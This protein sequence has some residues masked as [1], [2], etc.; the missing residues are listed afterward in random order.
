MPWKIYLPQEITTNAIHWYHLA[1]GHIG[2][3][4]LLDTIQ[5][6]FHAPGLQQKVDNVTGRC[7]ACQHMKQV[8]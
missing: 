3:H 8:G 4:H 7:D 5:M 2:A 1:L 6:H